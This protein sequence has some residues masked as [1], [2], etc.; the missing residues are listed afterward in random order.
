M[1]NSNPATNQ[2]HF[3]R[4]PHAGIQRSK[5]DRSYT[6]KTTL[7]A[8]Y[9]VP[10]YLDEVLP[11]DIVQMSVNS[12]CRLLAPLKTPVMDNMY[13]DWQFW[14]A[15]S[16]RLWTN[17]QKFQGAQDNPGDPTD[18]FIVPQLLLDS[19]PS[20]N[21]F[22]VGSVADY[23]GLPVGSLV[24]YPSETFINALPFRMYNWVYNECYRD[25]NFQDS[26]GGLDWEGDGPDDPSIYVLQKRGKRFD[27]FTS[28]L[29]QA[30]K[31]VPVD[32]PLGGLAPLIGNGSITGDFPVYGNGNPIAFTDGNV[33]RYLMNNGPDVS[34]S[35]SAPPGGAL[36][37][38]GV[39]TSPSGGNKLVGVATSDNAGLVGHLTTGAFDL[40]GGFAD[41]A[42]ATGIAT[43][44]QVRYAVVVQQ[45]LEANMRGGTRYTEILQS[46]W[47][48]YPEDGRLQRPQFLGGGSQQL[49][50]A[51]VPQTSSSVDG[52]PQGTLAAFVAGHGTTGFSQSFSE[53]GYIMGLCSIRSDM[54]YQ[55]TMHRMWSRKTQY[56]FWKP[57][58]APLGEQTILQQ[59]INFCEV[60]ADN[61]VV[62]AYQERGADYRYRPNVVS[63][64]MR[65]NSYIQTGTLDTWHLA[66]DWDGPGLVYL[67]G[68]FIKEAP[69]IDRIS[70]VSSEIAELW[71]LDVAF[72]QHWTRAMPAY[73]IPGLS[74]F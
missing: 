46:Q 17:W 42:N 14:F 22:D 35:N 12:I 26:A 69:P 2:G 29:P 7:N 45:I 72:T 19:D 31:G 37:D 32:F 40:S 60:H 64:Y 41:L 71:L 63:G 38:A 47:D 25:E 21:T 9:L 54:T 4:A 11:G 73:S 16:R 33:I 65:S 55:N 56:D 3:S 36:G 28:G 48:V 43:I 5:F 62:F 24:E 44:N 49:G 27:Y 39:A 66:Y 23:F 18:S 67:N 52:S 70:A 51:T 8:G 74:R 6:H 53:H 34:F 13:L 50:V 10:V 61:S 20:N 68:E 58:F 1:L 59:E 15:P 30:Q 57:Q